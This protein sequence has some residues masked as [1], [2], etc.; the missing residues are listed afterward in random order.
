MRSPLRHHWP[1]AILC[2]ICRR[3]QPGKK[4]SA[5]QL[6]RTRN[7]PI[8]VLYCR[9]PGSPQSRASCPQ[10]KQART[11]PKGSRGHRPDASGVRWCVPHH[12]SRIIPPTAPGLRQFSPAGN[13]MHPLL[14]PF[15]V[16]LSS[17]PPPYPRTLYLIYVDNYYFSR[18]Q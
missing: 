18:V 2:L 10:R 9:R 4:T 12:A 5:G 3:R 17:I 8:F 6:P 7:E 11:P 13:T 14:K 16:R 1:C 15:P